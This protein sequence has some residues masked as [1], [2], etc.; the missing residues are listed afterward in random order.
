MSLR[1]LVA[2]VVLVAV[3][4]LGT[5]ALVIADRRPPQPEGCVDPP[6]CDS[7]AIPEYER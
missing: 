3:I 5:V 7:I 2:L 1:R 4:V 6:E